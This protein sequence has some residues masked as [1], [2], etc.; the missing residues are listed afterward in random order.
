MVGLAGVG[1]GEGGRGGITQSQ[2]NPLPPLYRLS[3][4]F[5]HE[6]YG[7]TMMNINCGDGGLI[8]VTVMVTMVVIRMMVITVV[9]TMM[10]E[11]VQW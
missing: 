7:G 3:S 2:H 11:G 6:G 8:K 9:I 10:T 1:G 5:L 4:Q